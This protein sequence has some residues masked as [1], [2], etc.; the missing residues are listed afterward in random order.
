[1]SFRR[2][3]RRIVVALLNESSS[4]PFLEGGVFTLNATIAEVGLAQLSHSGRY[5]VRI[6]ESSEAN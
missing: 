5:V 3:P 4:A 2:C 1:M 6:L